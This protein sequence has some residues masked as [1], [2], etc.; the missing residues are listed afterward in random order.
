MPHHVVPARAFRSGAPMERF[1][2]DRWA[3]VRDLKAIYPELVPDVRTL[4]LGIV[5]ISPGAHT[6]LHRHNCEEVYYV[7]SGHGEVEVDGIREP[8]HRGDAVHIPE[9]R[10]HH[11]FNRGRTKLR[12][13]VVAGPMFV[14]LLPQWPTPTPYELLE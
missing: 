3:G 9:K 10:H 11:V 4:T 5:E 2:R 1:R 14:S 8:I 7:L 13:V 6:P 12:Y